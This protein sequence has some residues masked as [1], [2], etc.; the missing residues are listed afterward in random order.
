MIR[1]AGAFELTGIEDLLLTL[2][3]DESLC[4]SKPLAN[5]NDIMVIGSGGGVSIL[6]TDAAES[7]G[8]VLADLSEA[9]RTSLAEIIPDSESLGGAANPVEIPVDR[10]FGELQ[11]LSRLVAVAASDSRVGSVLVHINL[12]AFANNFPDDA[13]TPWT[14]VCKTLFQVFGR[15]GKALVIVLRNGECDRLT[16]RLF[17][18]G[19]QRLR[20]DFGLPVFGQ[21]ESA[22]AFLARLKEMCAH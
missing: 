7:M 6:I 8:L 15:T 13:A 10:M 19:I 22:L 12:I 4:R 1:Q 14:T 9:T 16:K 5:G 18:S 20:Q 17:D 21:M 2:Q 11:T 3:A